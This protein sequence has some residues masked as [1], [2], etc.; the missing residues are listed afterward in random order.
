MGCAL[1]QEKIKE[2]LLKNMSNE[3]GI[4]VVEQAIKEEKQ[5]LEFLQKRQETDAKSIAN[6][7]ENI[8]NGEN[9]ITRLQEED[10]KNAPVE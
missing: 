1:L 9:L 6:L 5:I 2:V 7:Q 4:A 8:A 3:S 10:K